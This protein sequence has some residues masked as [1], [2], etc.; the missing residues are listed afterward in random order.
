MTVKAELEELVKWISE[1]QAKDED[2]SDSDP[3]S[4]RDWD[5]IESNLNTVS[6]KLSAA[7][8]N[9]AGWYPK[10]VLKEFAF[11]L[12]REAKGLALRAHLLGKRVKSEPKSQAE[13]DA[14]KKREAAASAAKLA[15][16]EKA[17]AELAKMTAAER[18]KVAEAEKAK[19]T[20]A[21]RAKLA[22][23]EK[24]E[25]EQ[26]GKPPSDLVR[27]AGDAI[28]RAHKY[29]IADDE[30]DAASKAFEGDLDVLAEMTLTLRHKCLE[31]DGGIERPLPEKKPGG[32][33][34]SQENQA[35][36]QDGGR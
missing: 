7:R 6:E 10:S 3:P 17:A 32:E 24:R 9:L 15:A 5:N 31:L 4:R 27:D 26:E 35:I 1:L 20:A 16:T 28:E 21:E 14:A 23:A 19:V 29:L 22:E 36:A 2:D 8:A 12:E 33:A 34:G 30:S 13:K 18:D 25:R 11:D